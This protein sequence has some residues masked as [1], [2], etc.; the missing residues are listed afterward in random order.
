[1]PKQKI[2]KE[3][4]VEAAFELARS[5]GLEQISVKEIAEKVGCS[6]QPIYS[7]CEN[8]DGL[9]REVIALARKFVNQYVSAHLDRSDFFR[10]T[11]HAY[12]RLAYE[13]PY[14]FRMFVMHER[15]HIS[16]LDE[17]YL[18]ESSPDVAAFIA[19]SLHI[20]TERA[21]M[22]HLNLL[23]FTVGIGTILSTASPGIPME[24]I[25]EKLEQAF[26]AFRKQAV[27]K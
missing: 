7:Y 17:L 16:S 11:G 1:M 9:R 2:K 23:I 21:K 26:E 3:M 18:S 19:D 5:R 4:V 14:I 8:M 22:L 10:S 15:E 13:E 25:E 27:E 20:D 12:V 24:E 6:V